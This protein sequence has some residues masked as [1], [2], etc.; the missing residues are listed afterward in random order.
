MLCLDAGHF[1]PTETISD[2]LS[3]LLLFIDE[4]FPHVSREV[5]WDSDHVVVLNDEVRTIASEFITGN[6]ADRIP[7]ALNYFD[8][9]IS[10]IAA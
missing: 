10:R 7:I 3:S 4:L 5:R 8:A 2:K 1:H 6:Y 9:S